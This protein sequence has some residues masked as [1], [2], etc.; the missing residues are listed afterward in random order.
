MIVTCE[1]FALAEKLGLSAQALFDV[2]STASGQSW[3]LTAYCPV[4][5]PVPASPAN[6]DFNRG[7]PRRSC[8]RICG[9]RRRLRRARG[10]DAARR[11]SRALYALYVAANHGGEDFSAI[12]NFL[13]GDADEALELFPFQHSFPAPDTADRTD[14]G[15]IFPCVFRS[16]KTLVAAFAAL[17]M[18]TAVVATST[19]AEAQFFMGLRW[20]S[21]RRFP[22][23][24]LFFFFFSRRRLGRRRLAWRRL[25]STRLEA[26][27][28]V[29][30]AQAG[31]GV[32]E[33]A[34]GPSRGGGWGWDPGWAIAAAT[35][36]IGVAIA[37]Q[38]AYDGGPGC[39]V[40]RRVWTANGHY[41]GRR[42]GEHLHVNINAA[43]GRSVRPPRYRM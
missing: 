18:A 40:R 39:W 14:S 33:S 19:P 4:P 28:G 34:G 9:W 38:P 22:R 16:R 7:L 29:I 2:S 10:L 36:P 8:S 24:R 26:A 3:S 42:L 31:V 37:S 15:R 6:R 43:V 30:D 27:V 21:W 1:A 11:R 41:M 17:G 35:V 5:G 12:I 23:R 25:G 32:A 20:L 13:R